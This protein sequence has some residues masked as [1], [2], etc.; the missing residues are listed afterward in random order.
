MTEMERAEAVFMGLES[1]GGGSQGNA[2]G[3]GKGGGKQLVVTTD[4]ERLKE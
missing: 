4:K 1:R 2:N 3:L